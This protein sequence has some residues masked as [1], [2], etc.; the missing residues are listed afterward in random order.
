M[1]VGWKC[2]KVFESNQ[3][4]VESAEDFRN[5]F[6]L[7]EN[8]SSFQKFSEVIFCLIKRVEI[9]WKL[10]LLSKSFYFQKFSTA[11]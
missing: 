7:S 1:K 2:L 6:L 10:S 11:L 5:S 4:V 8:F 9:F 3:K